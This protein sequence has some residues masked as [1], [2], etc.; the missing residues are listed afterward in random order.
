MERI[1]RESKILQVERKIPIATASGKVL[2]FHLIKQ[3]KTNAFKGIAELK[4]DQVYE[5]GNL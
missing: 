1:W 4:Q 5:S 3:G 2:H